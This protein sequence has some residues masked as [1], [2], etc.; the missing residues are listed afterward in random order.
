LTAAIQ[1]GSVVIETDT[2]K[3]GFPSDCREKEEHAVQ[4]LPSPSTKLAPH[5]PVIRKG[6]PSAE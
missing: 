4:D 5:R 6:L 3:G 2:A 1:S